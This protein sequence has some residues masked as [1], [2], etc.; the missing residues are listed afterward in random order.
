MSTG[1]GER[2][3]VL[4]TRD[5]GLAEATSGR[6]PTGA[7]YLVVA[8]GIAEM[9]SEI[10]AAIARL[11]CVAAKEFSMV[12]GTARPEDGICLHLEQAAEDL[13][14]MEELAR[15]LGEVAPPRRS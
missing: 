2:T 13:G 9:S 3:E 12:S 8:R 6:E 14:R 4:G 5:D 7:G 11:T 10:R 15:R 1:T